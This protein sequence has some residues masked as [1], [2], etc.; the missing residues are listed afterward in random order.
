[1][2]MPRQW[3]A[4]ASSKKVEGRINM[5]ADTLGAGLCPACKT[6]MEGPAYC[7]SIPMQMCWDCRV[8]MPYPDQQHE[9]FKLKSTNPFGV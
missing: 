5:G 3:L 2:K 9:Q 4:A 7:A 1:M 8:A 6:K